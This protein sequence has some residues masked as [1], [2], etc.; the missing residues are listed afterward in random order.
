MRLTLVGK[1]FS[2]CT[3]NFLR[4]AVR[5]QGR[6]GRVR[7]ALLI[8]TLLVGIGSC[9][10]L[11]PFFVGVAYEEDLVAGYRVIAG[12][13]IQDAVIEGPGSRGQIIGPKVTSYGWNKD[14]IVAKQNPV[15]GWTDANVAL[16]ITHWFI[17]EVGSGK[18]HGPLTKEQYMEL[19]QTLGVP[20]DLTFTRNVE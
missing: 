7:G 19:R 3:H 16:Y 4:Q 14:F 6:T 8:I 18:V 10:Y 12:D 15:L 20:P 17:I 11:F 1:V 13:S 2:M 5:D 9:C